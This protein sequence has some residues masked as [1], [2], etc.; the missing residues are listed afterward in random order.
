MTTLYPVPTP[1]QHE[2]LDALGML[3]GK[4]GWR[5]KVRR[6]T[7]AAR[8]WHKREVAPVLARCGVT[9]QLTPE[10]GLAYSGRL[11][12]E[13]LLHVVELQE[14]ILGGLLGR[15]PVRVSGNG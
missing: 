9:M 15:R 3:A 12:V 4:P 8:A 1:D 7:A 6:D 2:L 11:G 10:G 5:P 14:V 13:E